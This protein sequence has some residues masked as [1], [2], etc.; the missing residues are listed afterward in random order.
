MNLPRYY[1]TSLFLSFSASSKASSC[2]TYPSM[3]CEAA[4]EDAEKYFKNQFFIL[5]G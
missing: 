1:K 4:L 5:A 3:F 2:P